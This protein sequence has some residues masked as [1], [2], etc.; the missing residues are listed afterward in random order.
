MA[1]FDESDYHLDMTDYTEVE[2][3]EEFERTDPTGYAIFLDKEEES[4]QRG[5]NQFV[6]TSR[7]T[8]PFCVQNFVHKW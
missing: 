5:F 3:V 1:C 8:C 7:E 2:E 4:I 6:D